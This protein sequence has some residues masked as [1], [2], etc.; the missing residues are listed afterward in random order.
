MGARAGDV[1]RDQRVAAASLK[2]IDVVRASPAGKLRAVQTWCDV[3]EEAE[4]QRARG[5]DPSPL[6]HALARNTAAGPFVDRIAIRHAE[7]R[8]DAAIERE[9]VR[10]HER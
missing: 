8:V 10:G 4:T 7:R 1:D 2:A 9:Q 3:R 5:Q 6:L